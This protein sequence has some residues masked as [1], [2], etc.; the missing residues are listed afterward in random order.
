MSKVFILY[1]SFYDLQGKELTIGGIQTYIK[2]LCS[3]IIKIDLIPIIV[4]YAEIKFHNKYNEIDVFGIEVSRNK[5]TKGKSKILLNYVEKQFDKKDIIIFAS[6]T[7]SVSVKFTKNIIAIQHGITWDMPKYNRKYY[8]LEIIHKSILSYFQISRIRNIHNLVCVDYNFINWI[9]TQL[10]QVDNNLIAIPNCTE[11]KNNLPSKNKE[12]IKIIFAR[13]FE[14]YRGT[15]LF[16][17]AIKTILDQHD[18]I[19][20]TFAGTGPDMNFLKKSFEN[21]PKVSFITY[22]PEESFEIHEKHHIS[23]IP[24][25]GSEGTSLSM[26]EAMASKCAVIGTNVG[27]IDKYNLRSLQRFTYQ[28]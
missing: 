4:Q 22:K 6:E 3:L 26:L 13:R 11:I 16:T 10:Y 9:R 7:I 21:N 14:L 19:E 20:V 2:Q 27:G 18:N 24:T 8:I 1:Q 28:S 17:G 12:N 23:V 5:N 15:R 25:L